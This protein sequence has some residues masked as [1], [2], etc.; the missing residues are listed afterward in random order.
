MKNLPVIE[1]LVAFGIGLVGWWAHDYLG[2]DLTEILV[3]LG[4]GLAGWWAYFYS[5]RMDRAKIVGTIFYHAE[6]HLVDRD[7]PWGS[8]VAVY[9][10]LVNVRKTSTTLANLTL[11]I[12]FNKRRKESLTWWLTHPDKYPDYLPIGNQNIPFKENIV[13][14]YNHINQGA[15]P[16]LGWIPFEGK[17]GILNE[18]NSFKEYPNKF[19][20]TVIDALGKKHKI[21]KKN[22]ASQSLRLSG[23][24]IFFPTFGLSD[25][26]QTDYTTLDTSNI[27]SKLYLSKGRKQALIVGLGGLEGGNAWASEDRKHMRDQFLAKGYAFLALGYFGAK[28]TP[29]LLD[30]IAIDDV[31]A[32]I[33]KATKRRRIDPKRI[34]IIG[35]SRGG[36]LALLLGSYYPDISCIVAL[37]P[38]HVVFPGHTPHFQIIPIINPLLSTPAWKYQGQELPFVP[39]NEA[40]APF[41]LK[42]DLH[43]AFTAMLQDAEAEQKA[44]IRVENTKGSILLVSDPQDEFSIEMCK[45]IEDRLKKHKDKYVYT[46]EHLLIEEWGTILVFLERQF[47]CSEKI[48]LSSEIFH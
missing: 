9:V 5:I 46:V 25:D 12:Y 14:Y 35:D 42:K 6:S 47:S 22:L 33:K 11:D 21:V 3:A 16:A 26:A 17:L 44:A 37:M 7:V 28:G 1:I 48:A 39:V 24:E 20:L 40:A 36:D 31:Y 2:H 15:A 18:D 19:V 27:E 10:Q 34:A 45:K 43:G 13:R 23:N 32:A 8:L 41:L 29:K 4:V 38:T 30:R